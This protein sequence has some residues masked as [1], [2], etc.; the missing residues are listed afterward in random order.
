MCP[1]L[2]D[3]SRGFPRRHKG[4]AS[5]WLCGRHEKLANCVPSD[6]SQATLVLFVSVN[7]SS[8]IRAFAGTRRMDAA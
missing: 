6:S 8:G 4:P 1:A 7:G 5:Y 3:R 2:E